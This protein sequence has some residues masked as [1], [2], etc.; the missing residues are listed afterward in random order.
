[1]GFEN[2][3]DIMGQTKYMQAVDRETPFKLVYGQEALMPMEYITP[4][5]HIATMTSIS[6]E[7]A[8]EE[9]LTQLLQL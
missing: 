6:D 1:M 3:C 5:L 8:V 2:S 7:G 9:W 4:I